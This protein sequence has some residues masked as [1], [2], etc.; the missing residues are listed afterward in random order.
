M[1][2]YTLKPYQLIQIENVAVADFLSSDHKNLD[3]KTVS[4][5]GEE[6]NKF[7]SFDEKEIKK[8]GDDYFDI[9]DSSM[10]NKD[11]IVLDVGCGMGRWSYY[12]SDRAKWVEAID[13]SDSIYRAAPFLQS[14]K[15]VRITKASV[16]NIPFA[17]ESFDFI[18]SL[19]VLHHVPNTQE[20]IHQCVKKIKK[21][22]YFL[23]YLYYNLDN[24][25]FFSKIL[26][27]ISNWGRKIIS[28]LPSK[29]K[30]I[31]CDMLAVVIY[32]PFVFLSR[33]IK[34][35]FPKKNGYKKIPLSYY[36]DKSFHVIRND[37]LDR[38]G[39]PLEQRFSEKQIRKMLELAGM[40]N[41]VF[42]QREPYW[43]VISK[44]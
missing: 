25:G 2:E 40:T 44:K 26:F 9:V 21:G 28:R 31:V 37:S 32:L 36:S 4:S 35:I 17:D 8:I 14:K 23:L 12:V 30:L 24:R 7:S 18:F 5:F 41:I 27:H 20:A 13:P 19:G 22:G 10:L 16:E 15:N 1:V 38:F 43:H 11:S 6:W 3:S 34:F 29:L 42:S 33:T 39:T